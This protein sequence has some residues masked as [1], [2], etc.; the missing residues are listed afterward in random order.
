MD[1]STAGD[2][3]IEFHVLGPIE[4]RVEGLAVDI[5][6]FRQRRLLALLL[7]RAGGVVESDALAEHVWDDDDRPDSAIEAAR[8]Y[9]SRLRRSFTD[10]GLDASSVLV[11]QSPGYRLS[12]DQAEIDSARFERLVLKARSQIDGGD[13]LSALVALDDALATWRGVPYQ[14]FADRSWIE[15]EV[16]RL[17]ELHRVAIEQ[18]AAARLDLGAHAEVVGELEQ[19]VADEPLRAR[20]VELLMLALYRSG[21]QAEALRAGSRFRREVAKVGLDPPASV[22]DL[23]SRIAASDDELQPVVA[24]TDTIRG[25]RLADKIGEGSFSVVY[26]SVQPSLGREVAV[27]QIRAELADRPDFIRRFETEAQTVAALEHP[28][29]VPLYDY[30]REPGSAYLV[31]RWLRGG[32]LRSWLRQQ[33][34]DADD[35]VTLATQI[36]SALATA[37]HAGVEHRDVRTANIFVDEIGNNYLGDFG[38]ATDTPNVNGGRDDTR[39]LG[40]VLFEAVTGKRPDGDGDRPSLSTL[41]P[42]LPDAVEPVLLRAILG[43]GDEAYDAVEDFVDDFIT[44]VS[45]TAPRRPGATVVPLAEEVVNPYKGLR[46]FQESDAD[47]FRGRDRLI[48]RLLHQLAEPGPAGRLVA[49]VGPSGSGKSSLVR[50]GLIPRVRAGGIAG[51]DT[52][53]VTTMLPG[54]RPF[55]ELEAALNRIAIAPTTGLAETMATRP[56]GLTRAVKSVL[57]DE[58]S[59]LLLVIDQF[60]ELFTLADD[61]TRAAFIAGLIAAVTDERSRLRIAI[62][63]RADHWHRPLQHPDLAHLLGTS[64]VTVTPMAANELERAIVDP[65]KAMGVTFEVGLVADIVAEVHGQPGALPLMQY[66]LSELFDARDAGLMELDTYRRLFGVAGGLARRADDLFEQSTETEREAIRRLFS[67]VIIPGEG[68]EDTRRRVALSELS[69][70]PE[71]VIDRYGDARLLTFDHDPVTREPTVEV[72]HE[73]LIR[74]WPRLRGWVD[75]DR[76]GLRTLR[77]LTTAA[78]EWERRGRARSELY[79]GGRL[80][81]AEAWETSHASDLT[82]LEREFLVASVEQREVESENERRRIQRLRTLLA[83]VSV[84]AVVALLAGVVALT[85]QRR[86][87][88]NA[89]RAAAAQAE[90]DAARSAAEDSAASERESRTLAEDSAEAERG[91]RADAILR[92]RIAESASLAARQP[93][94]AML[95]AAEA[96]ERSPGPEALGAVLTSIQ[97]PDGYLGHIPIRE[98]SSNDQWIGALDDDTV[99]VR[100]P[101]TIDVY[102]LT[103]RTLVGSTPSAA[104]LGRPL[105]RGAVGGGRF[106]ALNEVGDVQV[107]ESGSTEAGFR[108]EVRDGATAVGLGSDGSMILG[109]LD[110][111]EV[112]QSDRGGVTLPGHPYPVLAAALDPTA[113]VAATQDQFGNITVWDVSSATPIWS[114]TPGAPERWDPTQ[115]PIVVGRGEDGT[116]LAI[117]LVDGGP[118]PAPSIPQ[119]VVGVIGEMKFSTDGSRLYSLVDGLTAFDVTSGKVLWRIATSGSMF[120]FVELMDGTLIWGNQVVD[121]GTVVDT[122]A[123]IEANS[124]VAMTPDGKKLVAIESNGLSIWSTDGRQLVATGVAP[125]RPTLPRSTAEAIG[126]RRTTSILAVCRLAG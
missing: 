110:R 115:E 8:T 2:R 63:I 4:A 116:D 56:H 99:V 123:G 91:A 49:A 50:A 3:L 67:R 7:S 44:A 32:T 62:T 11:T 39:G 79:R 36:G 96:Y 76:E 26:R 71:A 13:A 20:P 6:G 101:W 57:P 92:Q 70:I 53:F 83:A 5:G 12:L 48:E 45:G 117:G 120:Q 37:H 28:H 24:S 107:I 41:R 66:L 103:S 69:A 34:L 55:D 68:T 111:V 38:I 9:V 31:M 72:A 15:P 73:A 61:A 21:R 10:A 87:D 106:A 109:F 114:W 59:E 112:Q 125:A 22:T 47:D 52:W 35:S 29:I 16:G 51:S 95:I 40:T 27:K 19:L 17:T 119:G 30:W 25:Y 84:V 102:D 60:E 33:R 81:S 89:T 124:R 105:N 85:Q 14:E 74:E 1:Q 75:D 113:S 42:D 80:E 54:P 100:T 122:L 98:T 121:D 93:S 118:R 104:F 88:Q 23:E 65:A 97:R 58:V 90:S 46:A 78:A 126:S 64:A 77:H 43:A 108:T 86:A 94:L 18:R 82:D